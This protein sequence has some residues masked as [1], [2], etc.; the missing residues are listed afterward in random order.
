MLL[1]L[2]NLEQVVDG[3]A[4]ARASWS[5][6]ARTCAL[7]VTSRELLRVQGEVEYPVPPLAEPEAVE[8]F[9]ERAAARARRR[10]S[11]ELCRA[12]GQPAAGDRAGRRARAACSRRR[13]SSSASRSASTCSRAAATPIPASRRCGRRSSGAT[14]CSTDE[15]QRLFARLA[16]FAGGCTLEAAEEVAERRPRHAAVAGRQEPAAPHRRALLDARDDPR[17]RARAARGVRRR[18]RAARSPGLVLPRSA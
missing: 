3:R 13:R 18:R 4:G 7:L 1:L 12:P 10:R 8:L 16:V 11:R 14:S 2:D 15:E 5:R 6:P 17:V 9:C